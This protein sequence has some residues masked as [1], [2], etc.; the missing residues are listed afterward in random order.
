M[1]RVR[2]ACT[3]G[4]QG[5]HLGQLLRVGVVGAGLIGFDA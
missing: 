3:E 2:R 5:I 1:Y 4:L